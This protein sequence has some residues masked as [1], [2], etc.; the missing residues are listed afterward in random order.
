MAY[1]LDQI[2]QQPVSSAS[3]TES[4]N[5]DYLT[6]ITNNCNVITNGIQYSVGFSADKTYYFHGK[7]NKRTNAQT[8]YIYL[9]KTGA[10]ASDEKK[11]Y[12]R[13]L[14]VDAEADINQWVDIELIFTPYI[15]EFDTISFEPQTSIIPI[16]CYE[17]LNEVNNK[18]S[19]NKEFI[20]MGVQSSTG[21]SM[22]L[23]GESIHVGKTGI[24]EI[25]NN[26]VLINFFSVVSAATEDGL[27]D[28]KTFEEYLAYLITNSQSGCI[29]GHSKKRSIIGYI[30]DCIY[31][32]QQGG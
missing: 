26:T 31:D 27:I 20:K 17:E 9:I 25:K 6:P 29:F 23:N 16:I 21:L 8:L 19:N 18:I 5:T 24:Y 7:V 4:P 1:V 30:L 12:L 13:T 22:V 10:S 14:K 11:Q 2:V 32:V 3:T 15:N 28:G